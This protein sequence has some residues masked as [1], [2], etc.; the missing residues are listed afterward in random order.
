MGLNT[1]LK[2]LKQSV[3]L[4]PLDADGAMAV[5]LIVGAY[6]ELL[7]N[8]VRIFDASRHHFGVDAAL[9]DELKRLRVR[10]GRVDEHVRD[11]VGKAKLVK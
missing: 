5:W 4:V 2:P 6:Y 11:S 1:V 3:K 8:R 10:I 9:G 7:D